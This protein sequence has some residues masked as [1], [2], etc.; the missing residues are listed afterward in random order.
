MIN[1]TV[2][3]EMQ[4]ELMDETYVIMSFLRIL[5]DQVKRCPTVDIF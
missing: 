1:G 2:T 4:R 3:Y 5:M